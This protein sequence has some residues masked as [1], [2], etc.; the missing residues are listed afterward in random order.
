MLKRLVEILEV[1]GDLLE[2]DEDDE[3]AIYA[4][5][6]TVLKNERERGSDWVFIGLLVLLLLFG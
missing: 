1:E 5:A 2:V 3:G 4:E 6:E